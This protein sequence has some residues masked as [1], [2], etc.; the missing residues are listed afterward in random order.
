MQMRRSFFRR[1][2]CAHGACVDHSSAGT[3]RMVDSAVLLI[4]N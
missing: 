3:L 4:H 2:Q 1:K